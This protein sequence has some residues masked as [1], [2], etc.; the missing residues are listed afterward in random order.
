MANAVLM[1]EE[2]RVRAQK[3][4]VVASSSQTDLES[5]SSESGAE[6]AELF[7]CPICLGLLCYP[8]LLPCGHVLC[9]ACCARLPRALGRQKCPLCTR[10]FAEKD[11]RVVQIGE[12]SGRDPRRARGDVMYL[13]P[14]TSTSAEIWRT[15]KIL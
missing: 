9:G 7:S 8:V 4:R 2:L 10:A 12:Q 6:V 1:R 3:V 15:Y 14:E 13:A 5:E 11:L